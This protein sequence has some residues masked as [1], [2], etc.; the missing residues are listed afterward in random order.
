[1][2]TSGLAVSE[3]ASVIQDGQTTICV[4]GGLLLELRAEVV[5]AMGMWI[6]FC[7]NQFWDRVSDAALSE[8]IS[9]GVQTEHP[10]ILPFSI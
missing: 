7:S 4:M 10:Q 6:C 8:V 5:Q 2:S 9:D 1:M 3:V